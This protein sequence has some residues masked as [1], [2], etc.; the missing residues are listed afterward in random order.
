MKKVFLL[1]IATLPLFF[2][3]CEEENDNPLEVYEGNWTYDAEGEIVLTENDV[4][5]NY[6]ISTD[7]MNV[8]V[9]IEVTGENQLEIDGEMATVSGNTLIFQDATFNETWT[10]EDTDVEISATQKKSGTLSDD[11]IVITETYTGTFTS[12]GTEGT[13]SGQTVYTLTR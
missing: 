11:R 8:D 1:L 12:E 2:V 7:E 13:L 6:T 4:L 10:I 3:S 9:E 5:E